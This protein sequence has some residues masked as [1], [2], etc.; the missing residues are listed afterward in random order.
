MDDEQVAPTATTLPTITLPDLSA[1]TPEEIERRR[2]LVAQ[3]RELREA[4]GP[5]GVSTEDLIH[6]LRGGDNRFGK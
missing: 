2:V 1:P 6:E 3:I 5:I 4:I